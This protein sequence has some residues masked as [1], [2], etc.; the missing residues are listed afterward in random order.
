MSQVSTLTTLTPSVIV[1]CTGSLI[2]IIVA[3]TLVSKSLIPIDF[4]PHH[5][6]L[7]FLVSCGCGWQPFRRVVPQSSCS[8]GVSRLTI[9]SITVCILCHWSSTGK[10]PFQIWASPCTLLCLVL[11]WLFSVSDSSVAAVY[12]NMDCIIWK[13]TTTMNHTYGR[14]MCLQVLFL[15]LYQGYTK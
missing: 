12:T 1:M 4:H 6:F 9:I 3:A 11:W 2:T 10:F 14:H 5:R 7:C 15:G 13:G 8:S